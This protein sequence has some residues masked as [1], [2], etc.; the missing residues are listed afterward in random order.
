MPE[1]RSSN[2]EKLRAISAIIAAV[3]I[4]IVV[5]VVGNMY[6]SALKE[7]EIQSRFVELA[8]NI[9][10]ELPDD[11]NRSIRI[12]AIQVIDQYSGV[13]FDQE[14]KRAL[15]TSPLLRPTTV[16]RSPLDRILN[17]KWVSDGPGL[18]VF[19]IDYTY[20]SAHTRPM[21][22]RVTLYSEAESIAH[23]RPVSKRIAEGVSEPLTLDGRIRVDAR[24]LLGQPA[25]SEFVEV[26]LLEEAVPVNV[27]QFPLR[28]LWGPA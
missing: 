4:P 2:W 7:R 20:D 22:V 15:E 6:T 26:V 16:L 23:G 21:Y 5:A 17:Y 27:K 8:V 18:I 13:P 9:L 19:E 14:A 10:K 25:E 1:E 12:W 24:K 28:R 11:S 3:V